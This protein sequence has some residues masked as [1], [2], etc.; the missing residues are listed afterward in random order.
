[1]ENLS[2]MTLLLAIATF[3]LAAIAFW[4]ILQN[5]SFH[6]K[7]RKERLLNEII[8]FA[9]E[10]IEWDI[11]KDY[12]AEKRLKE[13]EK[14]LMVI[15]MQLIRL[16]EGFN[17]ISR[18][19]TIILHPLS[20]GLKQKILTDAIGKLLSDVKKHMELLG[21][22]EIALMRDIG[23]QVLSGEFNAAQDKVVKH[24]ELLDKSATEIIS[25]ATK[26]KK[27]L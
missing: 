18:R 3:I 24:K 17:R 7:E 15:L 4:A 12:L 14:P 5:Y 21:L 20:R 8:E 25:E 9:T 27:N 2:L 16:S 19:G 6:K 11:E 23:A 13:A 26:L 22:Q 1:M 10:T